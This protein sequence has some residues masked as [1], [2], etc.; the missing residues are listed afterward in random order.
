[1]LIVLGIAHGEN[2][3]KTRQKTR[4]KH[5]KH[6]KRG[7]WRGL[8]KTSLLFPAKA[9]ILISTEPL[10]FHG[11]RRAVFFGERLAFSLSEN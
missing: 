11:R 2:F 1:V 3:I 6:A 7:P 8:S 9:C 4:K 10:R 5:E